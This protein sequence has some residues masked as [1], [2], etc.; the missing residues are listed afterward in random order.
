M[1]YSVY[2]VDTGGAC[3]LTNSQVDYCNVVLVAAL[4]TDRQCRSATSI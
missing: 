3:S 2:E 4:E 1:A